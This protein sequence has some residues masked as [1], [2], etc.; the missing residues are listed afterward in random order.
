MRVVSSSDSSNFD[1]TRRK[2]ESCLP[3]RNLV[4]ARY[5]SRKDRSKA[6]CRLQFAFKKENPKRRR[7][8]NSNNNNTFMRLR[9]PSST[10]ATG[11]ETKKR[12]PASRR[13]KPVCWLPM[14][15]PYCTRC[16]GSI[17]KESGLFTTR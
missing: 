13:K 3:E 10:R 12:D 4:Q 1:H 9:S 14:R 17:E 8:I 15:T 16:G 5:Y 6:I 2:E 11:R 7:S